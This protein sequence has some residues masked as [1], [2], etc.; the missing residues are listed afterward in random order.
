MGRQCPKERRPEMDELQFWQVSAFTC[1]M[2]MMFMYSI[3]DGFDLG[4]GILIGFVT[5]NDDEKRTLLS[6]ISPFWDGNEVWLVIAVSALFAAF[7][8]VFSNL[9]PSFYLPFLFIILLFIV[10]AVSLEFTYSGKSI[11]RIYMA[12]FSISSFL[13]ISLGILFFAVIVG[14]V[15]SDSSGAYMIGVRNILHP[16]PLIFASS[17]L[18]LLLLHSISYMSLKS[19][20]ALKERLLKKAKRIWSLFIVLFVT[21][22]ILLYFRIPQIAGKPLVPLGLLMAFSGAISYRISIGSKAE[23]LMFAFSTLGMGGVWLI[24]AGTMFPNIVNPTGGG[25]A[26]MTIY[27]SSAPINT[28]R[29]IVLLSVAGMV[30]IIAYA[31]FVYRIFRHGNGAKTY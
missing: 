30:A 21:G 14:G 15:P 20:G 13:A 11:S 2:F 8:P 28:L 25:L 22:M 18:M 16:L 5:E 27:N 12:L 1:I 9:L 26:T 31:F 24:A 7:P 29:I 6:S 19:D 3:L 10:R 17:W 23:R 4:L